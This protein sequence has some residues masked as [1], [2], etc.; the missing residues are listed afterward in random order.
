MIRHIIF[1][2]KC[3]LRCKKTFS[4]KTGTFCASEVSLEIRLNLVQ[5][6]KITNELQ[7]HSEHCKAKAFIKKSLELDYLG[8]FWGLPSASCV[9]VGKLSKLSVYDFLHL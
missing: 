3:I 1:T 7:I 6:P 9:T 2:V 5:N 8:Q 4:F